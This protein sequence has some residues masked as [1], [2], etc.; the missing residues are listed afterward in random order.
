[1]LYHI[2]EGLN[3]IIRAIRWAY[4]KTPWQQPIFLNGYDYPDWENEGYPTREGFTKILER[5]WLPMLQPF[6]IV[7][8]K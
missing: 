8:G 7:T 1:M 2:G 4:R 3:G 5:A 6:G